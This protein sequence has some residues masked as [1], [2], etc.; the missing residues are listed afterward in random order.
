MIEYYL[1]HKNEPIALMALDDSFE[2]VE[3]VKTIDSA[4][5]SGPFLGNVTFE[6]LQMWWKTRAIP[7]SRAQLKAIL[8]EN[9][10]LTAGEYLAN[11]FALSLTDSF[12]ICPLD[13]DNLAAH[14][15]DFSRELAAIIL[16]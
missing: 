12:W 11:H 4:V 7:G 8:E 3:G 15:R 9:H 14:T 2:R 10:C 1:M 16:P 5:R 13:I 6:N